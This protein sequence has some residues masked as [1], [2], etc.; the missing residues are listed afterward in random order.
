[1]YFLHFLVLI[2][3]LL[4]M[5]FCSA[6]PI[7][8]L[9]PPLLIDSSNRRQS[10]SITSSVAH[11]GQRSGVVEFGGGWRVFFDTFYQVLPVRDASEAFE[12]L[13]QEVTDHA[14]GP[15]RSIAPRNYLVVNN[16]F[17]QLEFFSY[18][19]PIPWPLVATLSARLLRP[20]QHGLNGMFDMR[21]VHAATGAVIFARLR[22]CLVAAAA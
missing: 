21:F 22:V 16:H 3:I 1:M 12:R 18:A 15:W 20:S 5:T 11:L 6:T 7:Q 13:F 17:L 14:Q 9:T 4:S 8:T 19:H 2:T 10:E